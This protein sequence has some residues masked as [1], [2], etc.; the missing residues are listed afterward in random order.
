MIDWVRINKL[1]KL[2]RSFLIE[3]TAVH[4]HNADTGSVTTDKLGRR[5]DCNIHTMRKDIDQIRRDKSI[6]GNMR[7]FMSMN[8]LC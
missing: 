6:V 1:R 5:M 4:N 7:N 3:A 2:A 8:Q